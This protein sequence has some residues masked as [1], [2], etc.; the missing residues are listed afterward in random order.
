MYTASWRLLA[1]VLLLLSACGNAP[2]EDRPTEILFFA[3][4]PEG[5]PF[6]LEMQGHNPDCLAFSTGLEPQLVPSGGRGIQSLD[7]EHLFSNTF[8]APYFFVLENEQQPVRAVFRNL[9]ESSPLN[10]QRLLFGGDLLT[11]YQLEPGQCRSVT[12]FSDAAEAVALPPPD[13]GETRV[14]VCSFDRDTELPSGFRCTD[15]P[16]LGGTAD[17]VDRHAIFYATIGDFAGSNRSQCL[18]I[19]GSSRNNCQTPASLF[20]HDPRDVVSIVVSPLTGDTS[21]DLKFHGDLYI[22]GVWVDSNT[23]SVGSD[24]ILK[25]DV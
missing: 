12:N 16:A 5:T 13:S 25:K 10:V 8:L 1:I 14:D 3:Q 21:P 23:P 19:Q 18:L 11:S 7:A 17:L 4:G 9:S 22:D 20:L 15:A 2:H 24:V 6:E